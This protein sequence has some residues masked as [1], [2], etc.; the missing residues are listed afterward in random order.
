MGEKKVCG[1]YIKRTRGANV[2]NNC[3]FIATVPFEYRKSSCNHYGE[4]LVRNWVAIHRQVDSYGRVKRHVYRGDDDDTFIDLLHLLTDRKQRM[5]IFGHG[6]AQDLTL[7]HFWEAIASRELQWKAGCLEDVPFWVQF[8]TE[9]GHCSAI[10][11]YNYYHETLADLGKQFSVPKLAD[12]WRDVKPERLLE[13]CER[14]AEIVEI[15]MIYLMDLHRDQQWGKWKYTTAGLSWE[16]WRHK[17]LLVPILVH[18]DDDVKATE[19]AAYYGP[20]VIILRTEHLFKPTYILDVNSLYPSQMLTQKFPLRLVGK[21]VDLQPG[22]LKHILRH[23]GAVAHVLIDSPEIPFPKKCD[24]INK[25]GTGRFATYLAGPELIKAIECGALVK[26]YFAYIYELGNPFVK[27]VKELY[28]LRMKFVLAGDEIHARLIKNVMNSLYG[29]FSQKTAR[30]IDV[31][32]AVAPMPWGHYFEVAEGELVATTFRSI[33]WSVQMQCLP[34]LAEDSCPIISAYITSYGR[35]RMQELMST[36]RHE[37][38]FYSDTDSL[39]VNE[40]G[41]KLLDKAREIHQWE[42]GKMKLQKIANCA[43]Y[44]GPKRYILDEEVTLAGLKKSARKLKGGHWEQEIQETASSVIVRNPD[45]TVRY[46]VASK[47]LKEPSF[48][49]RVLEDGRVMFPVLE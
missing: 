2:P 31:N 20:P 34:L 4:Y 18:N 32:K 46:H 17:F 15:A 47:S 12:S 33:G 13:Y 26:C 43:E 19:H 40:I 16:A 48:E 5:T 3:L 8:Q 27:F 44:F 49:G 41:L 37:N 29:K 24:G 36:A 14:H 35:V 6:L 42:L 1:H 21:D 9:K 7:L 25:Y 45:G 23:H 38:C 28:D 11:V 10:E 30:W 22:Q 39:H